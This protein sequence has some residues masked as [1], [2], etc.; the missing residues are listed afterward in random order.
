[1]FADACSEQDA[2]RL[3]ERLNKYQDDEVRI[4]EAVTKI[5]D[6]LYWAKDYF[7][8]DGIYSECRDIILKALK[9]CEKTDQ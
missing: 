5:I 1:M 6:K 3:C 7:K 4:G 2:L 8:D 9:E